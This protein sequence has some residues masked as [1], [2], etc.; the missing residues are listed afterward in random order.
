MSRARDGALALVLVLSF[1]GAVG[2]AHVLDAGRPALRAAV[3]EAPY[4]APDTAR[5]L[6]LGFEGL[7]GRAASISPRPSSSTASRRS[8]RACSCA[9]ST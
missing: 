8:I 6:A 5:R 7:A 1:A 4:L 9:S 2:M 3:D